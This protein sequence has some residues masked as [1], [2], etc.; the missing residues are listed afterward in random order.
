MIMCYQLIHDIDTP[1][2]H[3]SHHAEGFSD[4]EITVQ[5]DAQ[6]GEL[7]RKLE[8]IQRQLT[9]LQHQMEKMLRR[10]YGRKSEQLNPNQMMLDSII[11]ESLEQNTSQ[12]PLAAVPIQ[13]EV[14]RT[15]KASE[16][17]G[18]VPIPEH[19]ERVEILIDIPEEQKV[20]PETG[21]PLKVIT[22]E[23]SEKLEYRPGKL[24]VNVYKRPEYALPERA[25]HSQR[26]RRSHAGTSHRQV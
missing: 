25:I 2:G 16:H 15:R 1:P 19:L 20:C 24:I 8:S 14:V 10:L 13:P 26:H 3:G 11:L 7:A 23:V 6:I 12:M 4:L 17:H 21:E 18:R 22:V 5:K 9:T